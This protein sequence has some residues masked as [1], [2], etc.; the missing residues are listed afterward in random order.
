MCKRI[1][2]DEFNKADG[3]SH[4]RYRARFVGSMVCDERVKLSH[5]ITLE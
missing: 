4:R 3:V 1:K 2:H 5:L